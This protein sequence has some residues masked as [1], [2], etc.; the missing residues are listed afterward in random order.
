MKP[1]ALRSTM[2]GHALITGLILT[3]I[4]MILSLAG[5]DTA[6]IES[7]V[8]SGFQERGQLFQRAESALRYAEKTIIPQLEI[9][10]NSIDS[11][12]HTIDFEIPLNEVKALL[13]GQAE[14]DN[15]VVSIEKL[16]TLA[17]KVRG[18]T[19]VNRDNSESRFLLT[20]YAVGHNPGSG[21]TLTGIVVRKAQNAG[22]E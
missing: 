18:K 1:V 21:T 4:L 12:Q 10:L 16:T 11:E 2:S 13:P 20:A 14:F 7:K 6:I 17:S 5:L 22:Y 15:P 8:A 9:S 3:I 19:I